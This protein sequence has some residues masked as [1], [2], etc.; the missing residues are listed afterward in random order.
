[1][2]FAIL[3]GLTESVM[4]LISKALLLGAFVLAMVLLFGPY[5]AFFEGF[6]AFLIV[7]AVIVGFLMFPR[8]EV[9]YVRT[10]VRLIRPDRNRP[11][12]HD[13]L[14]VRVEPARLWLLFVPTF[15]AVASLVFFAA[16][17]PTKFSSLNWIFSSRFAFIGTAL[18][19]YPPL[20]VLVLVTAWI[21]ERRVMRHADACSARSFTFSHSASGRIVRVSYLFMGEHSEYYAGEC[22]Y[23]GL[24]HPR[25][26]ETIVFHNVKTPELNKIAM[27]FLFHRL[28][29]LGR[30][31][32]DLD[33]QT[34]ATQ[35]VLAETTSL[36]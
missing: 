22:R 19:I 8:T 24:V 33:E 7:T 4:E 34:V 35:R 3:Y 16:S 26:L 23:F 27:G 5:E 1:M 29:I 14:A 11:L 13:L 36:S 30:G 32:T 6:M 25:E 31:V 28:V 21:G 9:F 17:G 18:C 2:L 15:L 20:L 12:E 10:T